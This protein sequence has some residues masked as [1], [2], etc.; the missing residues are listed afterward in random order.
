[1]LRRGQ[2]AHRS[3]RPSREAANTSPE[4]P[5]RPSP[6]SA[7]VHIRTTAGARLT[8]SG[9]RLCS[10]PWDPSRTSLPHPQSWSPAE[11]QG[12]DLPGRAPSCS[13]PHPTQAAQRT[14]SSPGP[15]LDVLHA[16]GI[17]S[18]SPHR[19]PRCPG[20]GPTLVPGAPYQ[21][22]TFSAP[23]PS[24][25]TPTLR[26]GPPGPPLKAPPTPGAQLLQT[27]PLASS[28]PRTVLEAP[29]GHRAPASR[30][31]LQEL[32]SQAGWAPHP[33]QPWPLPLEG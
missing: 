11:D 14:Q 19:M 23:Q 25:H 12:C 28:I 3:P 22:R 21:L 33:S 2:E 16:E 20:R 17:P 15:T 10:P 30:S 29:R 8:G 31:F 26:C 5:G 6:A 13:S 7:S 32:A 24:H 1:M 9:D 4:L 27:L 18:L